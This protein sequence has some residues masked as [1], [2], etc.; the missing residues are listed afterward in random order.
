MGV[1]KAFVSWAFHLFFVLIYFQ[2]VFLDLGILYNFWGY[3][4]GCK[5]GHQPLGVDVPVPLSQ[6]MF[7][8]VL[9]T[10]NVKLW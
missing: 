8:G 3:G 10:F 2:S 5:N 7:G 1:V 6:N 9:V 4:E